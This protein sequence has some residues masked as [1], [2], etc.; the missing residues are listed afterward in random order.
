MELLPIRVD[1]EVVVC[2][3]EL[4]ERFHGTR[5]V[6]PE[7][8]MPVD[9]RVFDDQVASRRDEPVVDLNPLTDWPGPD[10]CI[11]I[12]TYTEPTIMSSL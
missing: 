4:V 12:K 6:R 3:Q 5:T 10:S 2:V 9:V 1:L 7:N 8:R 11:I